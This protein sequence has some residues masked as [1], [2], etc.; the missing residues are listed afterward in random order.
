MAGMIGLGRVYDLGSAVVPVDLSGGA[1]TGKRIHLS[2]ASALAV[3]VF[4]GAASTG[5]DPAFT[6]GAYAA[7]SGGSKSAAYT[8]PTSMYKKSAATLAGTE[9]WSKVA[10]TPSSNVVTLT[11]EQG[12]QGIYVFE[13]LGSQLPD[14]NPYF[15]V[16]SSDAGSVAQLGGVFYLLHD[17]TVQRTPA[18]LAAQNAA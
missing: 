17:L 5:T 9:S 18:N 2:R 7:S 1:V 3:V 10:V 15:E 8:G 6:F 4:K 14:G 12:N 16:D 13:I 11:G